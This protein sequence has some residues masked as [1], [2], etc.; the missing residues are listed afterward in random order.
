MLTEHL[1]A[2]GER[3][4]LLQRTKCS[5]TLILSLLSSQECVLKR[6]SQGIYLLPLDVME[7]GLNFDSKGLDFNSSNRQWLWLPGWQ[8]AF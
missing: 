8:K 6:Q 7:K 5:P 3:E 2:P 1:E 4:E